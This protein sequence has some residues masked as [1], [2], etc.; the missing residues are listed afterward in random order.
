[1]SFEQGGLKHMRQSQQAGACSRPPGWEGCCAAERLE[2]QRLLPLTHLSA[3]HGCPWWLQRRGR[4]RPCCE[5]AG[6]FRLSML[7]TCN[8]HAGMHHAQA[9]PM[10]GPPGT[11]RRSSRSVMSS[12]ADCAVRATASP[13]SFKMENKPLGR[14]ERGCEAKALRSTIFD[15]LLCS[16]PTI[17][18][19]NWAQHSLSMGVC[20]RGSATRC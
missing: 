3:A 17:G 4:P 8:M 6:D 18:A 11:H 19:A 5:Q 20:F 9:C 14:G 15:M 13:T 1:M 7:D 2:G 16:Q 12:P 10:R